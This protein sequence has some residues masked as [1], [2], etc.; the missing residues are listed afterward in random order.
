MLTLP[1]SKHLNK[2][3][4]I[5]TLTEDLRIVRILNNLIDLDPYWLEYDTQAIQKL[6]DHYQ[7]LKSKD[8]Q[9]KK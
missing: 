3:P 4:E 1:L 7:Y 6:L 5:L 2:E 8:F 9:A